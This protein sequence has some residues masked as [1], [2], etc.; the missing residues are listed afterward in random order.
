MTKTFAIDVVAL[1]G[2]GGSNIRSY[3]AT[4]GSLIWDRVLHPSSLGRLTDPTG[5]G[6]DLTFAKDESKDILV[7]SN[8]PA[9]RRLAHQSGEIIWEW[10]PVDVSYGFS[11]TLPSI[12]K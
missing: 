3:R 4:T 2:P 1:S 10:T 9:V 12:N 6:V 5:A 8:P 7:L 11:H